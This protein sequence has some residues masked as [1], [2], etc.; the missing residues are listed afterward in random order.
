M[1]A[2]QL[3]TALFGESR[4]RSTL[5]AALSN[6]ES[7]NASESDSTAAL[8]A[9]LD[10]AKAQGLTAADPLVARCQAVLNESAERS[11]LRARLS[12]AVS[13]SDEKRCAELLRTCDASARLKRILDSE[14][15]QKASAW[16]GELTGLRKRLATASEQRDVTALEEAVGLA[17][18]P[19]VSVALESEVASARQLITKLKAAKTDLNSAL[20][21]RSIA[22]LATAIDAALKVG[23]GASDVSLA[24]ARRT[25]ARWREIEA[26][27]E[28]SMDAADA[29]QLTAALAS[30][31]ECKYSSE[32]VSAARTLRNKL[33]GERDARAALSAALKASEPDAVRQALARARELNLSAADPAMIACEKH[34][35][36]LLEQDKLRAALNKAVSERDVVGCTSLLERASAADLPDTEPAVQAARA[37]LKQVAEMRKR[38]SGAVSFAKKEVDVLSAAISA[39]TSIGL[40]FD[41]A[42][43]EAQSVLKALKDAKAKCAAAVEQRSLSALDAAIERATKLGLSSE[44]EDLSTAKKCMFSALLCSFFFFLF[45]FVIFSCALFVL[46]SAC[47]PARRRERTLRRSAVS[48]WR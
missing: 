30:A 1:S 15:A 3:Q 33:G 4:V 36:K 45:F 28:R 38:L 48:Q 11:K 20:E 9:A 24:D 21:N 25:L 17:S 27:L 42:V 18:A 7:S 32:R 22:A 2:S 16:L 44:D 41:R 40:E 31:D 10:A 14:E 35:T 34:L 26:T 13:A 29:A 19:S 37:W 5:T 43:S 46:C 6:A 8:S 39:C 23:F 12:A 47:E